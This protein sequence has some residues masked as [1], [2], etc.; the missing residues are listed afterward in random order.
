MEQSEREQAEIKRP[1]TGMNR[2]ESDEAVKLPI[3]AP[4]LRDDAPP[5]WHHVGHV[6][7]G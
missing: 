4:P 5:V 3:A 1:G 6:L 2:P 7:T